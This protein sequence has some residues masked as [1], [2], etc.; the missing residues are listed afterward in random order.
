MEYIAHRT[1][2]IRYIAYLDGGRFSV[3]R[4]LSSSNRLTVLYY[5]NPATQNSFGVS[6]PINICWRFSGLALWVLMTVMLST[7]QSDMISLLRIAS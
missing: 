5:L 4:V 3:G 2:K 6:L 1:S 7:D